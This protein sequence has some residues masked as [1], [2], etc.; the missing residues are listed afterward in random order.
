VRIQRIGVRGFFDRIRE[1]SPLARIDA[2]RLLGVF[3]TGGGGHLTKLVDRGGR[4]A[5]VLLVGDLASRTF[6]FLRRLPFDTAMDLAATL[7]ADWAADPASQAAIATASTCDVWGQTAAAGAPL[8]RAP[9]ELWLGATAMRV[10]YEARTTSLDRLI[11]HLPPTTLAKLTQ[12]LDFFAR[13]SLVRRPLRNERGRY[14]PMHYLARSFDAV[15]GVFEESFGMVRNDR[16][17][18]E[19]IGLPDGGLL[20]PDPYDDTP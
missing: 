16:D 11:G 18:A 10:E 5:G 20:W 4:P 17:E 2:L 8:L 15:P 13:G 3:G 9:A 7:L 6:G 19:A 12:A 14:I 1:A